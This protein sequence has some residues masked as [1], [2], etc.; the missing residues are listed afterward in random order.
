NFVFRVLEF[1][2]MEI[3]YFIKPGTSEEHFDAWL[4]AMWTWVDLL[5]LNREHVR[6][7]E[8]DQAELSHYSDRTLD[9]EY[10]FP[11]SMGWKE[12]YGLANRTDFD[13][14]SHEEA[15]GVDM[16]YFDQAENT[17]YK[18]HVIEP[19]FGVERSFLTVLIDAYD[20]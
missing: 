15:S 11:G 1:E 8:H 9:F 10:E 19:T 7:R 3:E 6:V 4:D 20:E 5:G 13:L 18:P 2:Q 16:S 14:R 12:L 17:R